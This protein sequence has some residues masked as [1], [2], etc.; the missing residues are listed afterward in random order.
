[1]DVA[2]ELDIPA[3]AT[4]L[5]RGDEE[6]KP[7]PRR[8]LDMHALAQA[9]MRL[10]DAAGL[11][12]VSMRTVSAEMGMTS[13]ALYRY[14]KSKQE[15]LLMM[16][17]EA[18]GPPPPQVTQ[19][20]QEWRAGL[21]SWAQANRERLRAHPWV[22]AVPVAESAILPHQV[23]WMECGLDALAGTALSERQKLSALLLVNVYVRGQTQ[24]ALGFE[25]GAGD[26]SGVAAGLL[27]G[28]RLLALTDPIR[29][30]RVTAAMNH[31]PAADYDS[32]F[33][34]GEFNFGLDAVLDGIQALIAR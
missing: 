18:L 22:L 12:S 14:V 27:F 34:T 33:S 29:Y 24:L 15:L 2:D 5:W 10:A 7:G 16:V 17:D 31:N 26:R 19:A 3:Y 4:L 23:Q 13:M 20:G 25:T 11:D 8:S 32:D 30:P 9:G 1:M 21:T 28:Q 6:T